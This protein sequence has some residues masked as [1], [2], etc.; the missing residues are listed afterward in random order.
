MYTP[1]KFN[2]SPLKMDAWKTSAFPGKGGQ[3]GNSSGENS[4]L[5]LR[6]EYM[7]N[8]ALVR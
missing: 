6:G 2:S 5:N 7:V 4:L 1:L 8:T 3:K